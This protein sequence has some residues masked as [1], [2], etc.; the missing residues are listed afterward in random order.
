M[1]LIMISSL[2]RCEEALD[3]MVDAIAIARDKEFRGGN[4]GYTAKVRLY[5]R[6]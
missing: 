4:C 3:S 6:K 5:P 2:G 1:V